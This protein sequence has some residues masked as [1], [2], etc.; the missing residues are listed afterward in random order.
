MDSQSPSLLQ[1]FLA[2]FHK[3]PPPED[4]NPHPN[5]SITRPDIRFRVLDAFKKQGLFFIDL[6]TGDY[7]DGL[8][9]LPSI[10]LTFTPPLDE[11][12][13]SPGPTLGFLELNQPRKPVPVEDD[14]FELD[15]VLF[16]E[17]DGPECKTGMLEEDLAQ[18]FFLKVW[19]DLD[20]LHW[21]SIV[22]KVIDDLT[23]KVEN[24][25]H[26]LVKFAISTTFIP[27]DP[28]KHNRLTIPKKQATYIDTDAVSD[29]TLSVDDEE[30]EDRHRFI[31]RF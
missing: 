2:L 11:E 1:R 24:L 15:A 8:I 20:L 22:A 12:E 25:E 18:L 4:Y 21:E 30:Y 10:G 16:F 9:D 31:P 17:Y 5:I 27:D 29:K 13:I 28:A 26:P 14:F 19:N 3:T 23:V 7:V 6:E